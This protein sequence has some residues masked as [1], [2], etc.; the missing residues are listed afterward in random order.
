MS[1]F[2]TIAN[3]DQ[4]DEVSVRFFHCKVPIFFPFVT[5]RIFFSLSNSDSLPL[6]S[7]DDFFFT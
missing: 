2:I 6:A 7:T 5:V 1:I 4:L 3:F